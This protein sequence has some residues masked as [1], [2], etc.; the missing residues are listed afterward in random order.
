[1]IKK[2]L[3]L[4]VLTLITTPMTFAK[5]SNIKFEDGVYH[6]V[7]KGEKYKKTIKFLSSESLITNREA[8]L[9]ANA[10]LTI[11]AGFFDPNN[12]KS[13]SYIVSDRQT[14]DDPMFNENLTSNPALRKNLDKILNRSEFRVIQCDMDN[15]Y[16]YEIVPHKSPVDFGCHVI[17]SAQGGPLIYPQLKLEEEFFVVKNEKGEVIR[18]S[19]SVLQK[20]ERTLIGLKNTDEVHILIFTNEHK[21]DMYEAQIYVKN[22]GLD[23]AMAFDGG[24][25]TSMNY[26]KKYEYFSS[27]GNDGARSLKSFMFV[28]W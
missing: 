28:S 14:T 25:S 18:E 3:I 6:I 11:N 15:D 8:H 20:C 17:T 16:Y 1:M 12:E 19:A 5:S 23:R 26:L 10:K 21:I 13:I 24:S 7:L 22:L 9:K 27:E 2:I 4:F